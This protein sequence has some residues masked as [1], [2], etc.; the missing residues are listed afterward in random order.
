MS[1]KTI[2]VA[3][4]LLMILVSCRNQSAQQA[5]QAPPQQYPIAV[6]HRGTLQTE[7]TYP[8]TVRGQED[9]EIRPRIDGFIEQIYIDEGAVVQQ[10]QTL[11][12]INSPASEQAYASANAALRSAEASLDIAQL[13][14]NRMRPLAEKNIISNVQLE[15]Y[16]NKYRVAQATVSEANATLSQASATYGWMNVTSPISG[17]AGTIPYRQ[18]SLVSSSN[19]LTT[20]SNTRNVYAYFSLNERELVELLRSYEG[21]T[22]EDKIRNMPDVSLILADGK[23]YSQKG[24]IETISGMVNTTTGTATLRASF[25][26]ENLLLRSGSSGRISIPRVL[27]DVFEVPQKATFSIMDRTLVY[28]VQGDSV[29]Q[30]VITV[31]PISDGQRYAVTGGIQEGDTIV[32]DGIATLSNGRRIL[33]Q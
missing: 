23:V 19:V 29:V 25:P 22:Q 9:I 4:L 27:N 3:G 6:M 10:G 2:F 1:T 20:I 30:T 21:Q 14:V 13:D 5:Q 15:T 32:T 26:N 12:R 16:E 31:E 7:S 8:V 17:V 28:K 33:I 11:F 18:G 24:R